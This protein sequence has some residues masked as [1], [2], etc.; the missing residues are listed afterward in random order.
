MSSDCALARLKGL[1]ISLICIHGE[2]RHHDAALSSLA[3]IL[4][5]M[6]QKYPQLNT[7]IWCDPDPGGI[8]IADN[9]FRLVRKLGGNAQFLKMGIDVFDELGG[10]LLSQESIRPISQSEK[11]WL[12]KREVHPELLPLANLMLSKEIKG[13]QEALAVTIPFKSFI[14]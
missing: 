1:P 6:Y 11:D 2:T 12:N 7:Y 10:V 5:R 3:N 13:E 4:A 9:A 14:F 8:F